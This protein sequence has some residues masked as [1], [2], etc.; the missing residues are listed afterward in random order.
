MT[1]NA[2]SATPPEQAASQ[3]KPASNAQTRPECVCGGKGPMLSQMLEMM[4]PSV[5]AGEHFK[6]ARLEFLKGVRELLDQRIES[7]SG[8]QHKGTK[9]NVE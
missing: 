4:M 2:G 6:N 3:S 5:A 1:D 9:V 7:L 8:N